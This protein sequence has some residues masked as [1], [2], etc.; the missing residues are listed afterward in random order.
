MYTKK[1]GGNH[2]FMFL[3]GYA[4]HKPNQHLDLE[5]IF[6]TVLILCLPPFGRKPN[7]TSFCPLFVK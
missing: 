5:I 3:K 4:A 2:K 7:Y 6:E 1:A